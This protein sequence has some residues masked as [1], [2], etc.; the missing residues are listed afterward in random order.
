MTLYILVLIQL[1]VVVD[2]RRLDTR[3]GRRGSA[4]K[5]H[6]HYLDCVRMFDLIFFVI[7][8]F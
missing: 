1:V 8:R 4:T 7:D 2:K 3:T 6:L 5:E